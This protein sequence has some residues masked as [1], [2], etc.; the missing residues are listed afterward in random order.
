MI[1]PRWP[2]LAAVAACAGYLTRCEL[3]RRR[4][5]PSP[6]LEAS[7]RRAIGD[8]DRLTDRAWLMKATGALHGT[9]AADETVQRVTVAVRA[10]DGDC[11][12]YT[13]R[14]GDSMPVVTMEG[15]R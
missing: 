14:R 7:L 4:S 12:A 5:A 8:E 2:L 10:A 13:L 6:C 15:A 3:D 11:A 9:L 1:R